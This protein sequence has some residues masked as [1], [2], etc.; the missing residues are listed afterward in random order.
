MMA[1][2]PQEE[3]VA[4]YAKDEPLKLIYYPSQW[5]QIG[6]RASTKGVRILNKKKTGVFPLGKMSD[7]ALKIWTPSPEKQLCA[8]EIS[9]ISQQSGTKAT[10]L[11]NR[12]I[13]F[14]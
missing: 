3:G 8:R 4:R 6:V 2:T 9:R 1:L 14:N 5:E 11:I 7:K 12:Q 13:R 10:F